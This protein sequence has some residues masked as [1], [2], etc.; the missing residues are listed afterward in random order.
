LGLSVKQPANLALNRLIAL[1]NSGWRA[2][3]ADEI[4]TVGKRPLILRLLHF[5]GRTLQIFIRRKLHRKNNRSIPVVLVSF[6]PKRVSRHAAPLAVFILSVQFRTP[7]FA[8]S[9][10]YFPTSITPSLHLSGAHENLNSI[11][12]DVWYRVANQISL[13]CF[14][15]FFFKHFV[16]IRASNFA[17]RELPI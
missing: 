1:R 15:D 5:A 4:E 14:C 6:P 11:S 10:D 2:S 13:T 12:T 3:L 7:R 8:N 9:S 16:A 17:R